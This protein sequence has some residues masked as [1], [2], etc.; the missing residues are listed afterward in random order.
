MLSLPISSS[1]ASRELMPIGPFELWCNVFV[2]WLILA[3][4]NELAFFRHFSCSQS[5]L[6][7]ALVQVVLGCISIL[8]SSPLTIWRDN[9]SS[10]YQEYRSYRFWELS[11]AW[12]SPRFVGACKMKPQLLWDLYRKLTQNSLRPLSTQHWVR[13]KNDHLVH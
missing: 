6:N 11:S 4:W 12:M 5:R 1:H 3:R 8:I 9:L 2:N 7:F 13:G 10:L